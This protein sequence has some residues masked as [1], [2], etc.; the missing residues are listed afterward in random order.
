M[1]PGEERD[2]LP[3]LAGFSR[4]QAFIDLFP[5]AVFILDRDF[6]ILLAN[7]KSANV[8][9]C[10]KESL[11]GKKCFQVV[12][13]TSAPPDFCPHKRFLSS[14]KAESKVF[15]EEK[16]KRHFR[17]TVLPLKDKEGKVLGVL[18]LW[19]DLR[20]TLKQLYTERL[21][22]KCKVFADQLDALVFLS[23]DDYQITFANR[24]LREFFGD[25]VKGR[26]C[27]EVFYNRKTPCPWCPREEVQTSPQRH[28]FRN[29]RDARWYYVTEKILNQGD[30]SCLAWAVDVTSLKKREEELRR[31]EE[32]LHLLGEISYSFVKERNWS[33]LGQGLQKLLTLLE[34]E[35]IYIFER[36]PEKE[37]FELRLVVP[38]SFPS[39]YLLPLKK[40]KKLPCRED[41]RFLLA[42]VDDLVESDPFFKDQGHW[43]FWYSLALEGCW[44]FIGGEFTRKPPSFVQEALRALA[45][46]LR[47]I[48]VRHHMEELL[49]RERQRLLVV[50]KSM[51]DGVIVTDHRGRVILMNRAA[52]EITG[53][54]QAFAF[55]K[56]LEEILPVRFSTTHQPEDL[57]GAVL[58]YGKTYRPSRDFILKGRDGRT[59][60]LHLVVAPIRNSN[61]EIEGAVL[62][63]RDL[64]R[65]L[66]LEEEAHRRQ[67]L[68]ALEVMAAGLAHDFNNLLMAIGGH[69]TLARLTSDEQKRERSLQRAEQAL[70]KAQKL[71]ERLQNFAKRG[72]PSKS[73]ADLSKLISETV[74]FILSGANIT[75][76]LD[77][78]EDLWRPQVDEVQLA[79]VLQNLVLNAREAMPQGGT[80]YL[81][82]KNIEITEENPLPLRPGPYVRLEVKDT[83]C[84]IPPHLLPHIFDPY[85]TTKEHGSGLGLAVVYAIVSDHDGYIE[86]N[87]KEGQGT[88]FVIYLPADTGDKPGKEEVVL[89]KSTPV[90]RAFRI[91]V[92]DDEE[93]VREIMQEMLAFLGYEVDTASDAE[94]AIHKYQRAL[95]EGRRYD[96]V[97]L[98][99]TLP[100]TNGFQ[101][102]GTLKKIDPEVQA[103]MASG[104]ADPLF[105]KDADS[106]GVKAFL[107]KPF[108][109]DDLLKALEKISLGE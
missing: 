83:G 91:L 56:P 25:E 108:R 79:Q 46:N 21:S 53:W 89:E 105:L 82:A 13:G 69:L 104:Y 90:Q 61:E 107:K 3:N 54:A 95:D 60:R 27:Y 73:P 58:K 39:G 23:A 78:P 40:I 50:L 52:S 75:C 102:L 72:L 62:V 44:G 98:D 77:I 97:V 49:R 30:M 88:S 15:Y 51:A 31:R 4:W 99:F 101:I 48:L 35:R 12:H 14:G 106:Y 36:L 94:E 71:T 47:N 68:Q 20:E 80:L 9:G 96:A 74:E 84:G 26:K 33:R 76:R 64:T 18:H 93:D 29:P 34:A 59:H 43:A 37:A 16:V 81:R 7:E 70:I 28:L 87:S 11:L 17:V 66:S 67:K 1:S 10:S 55:G 86:V 22:S 24:A 103:I 57:L 109:L 5:F 6:R 32:F 45:E 38:S 100:G 2:F 42:R 63:F 8:L 19:E 41:L 65:Y 85:F 92:L